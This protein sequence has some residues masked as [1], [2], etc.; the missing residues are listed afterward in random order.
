MPLI[1]QQIQTR[2]KFFQIFWLIQ[3][4]FSPALVVLAEFIN[5]AQY[6]N[7]AQTTT[8]VSTYP[9]VDF[10][11]LLILLGALLLILP[12][13][14]LG[15]T[16]YAMLTHG[17]FNYLKRC[18]ESKV[19]PTWAVWS[20]FIPIASI[21]LVALNLKKGFELLNLKSLTA[22]NNLNYT[23][24]YFVVSSILSLGN[25]IYLF[26]AIFSNFNSPIIPTPFMNSS[27]IIS[28]FTMILALVVTF[29]T[30]KTIKEIVNAIVA[31]NTEQLS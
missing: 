10:T 23:I 16:F 27:F 17:I 6:S 8:A 20:I 22:N 24:I 28:I 11:P 18:K 5:A 9:I 30:W 14:I 26:Y 4:I 15:L 7:L 2:F 12:I 1:V 3:I 13:S 19:D 29:F 21:I 31:E 25:A